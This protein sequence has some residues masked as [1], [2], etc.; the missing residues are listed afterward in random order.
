[1]HRKRDVLLWEVI[2]TGILVLAV[3]VTNPIAGPGN[4]NF[5]VPFVVGCAIAL[6][7]DRSGAHLNPL[8]TG[9]TRIYFRHPLRH[10]GLYLLSEFL[11][12]FLAV[13]VAVS[14][15]LPYSVRSV[16][17]VFDYAAAPL[18]IG[19]EVL[20]SLLLMSLMSLFII[21]RRAKWLILFVPIFLELLNF[22]PL[23][24][25]QMNPAVTV[26]LML[27]GT[28]SSNQAIIHI[29][30]QLTAMAIMFALSRPLQTLRLRAA[31]S[32]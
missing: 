7:F 20:A 23:Y 25:S 4:P 1:M 24:T 17:Q 16:P 12:V 10:G 19:Q 13:A 6:T 3:L 11:G 29:I 21:L 15:P 28:I 14:L 31:T 27:V 9:I 18:I 8:A 5:L 2:G 30:G 22:T 26:G 32:K